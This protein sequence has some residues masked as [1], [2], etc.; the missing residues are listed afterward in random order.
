[1]HRQGHWELLPAKYSATRRLLILIKGNSVGL[2]VEQSSR[3]QSAILTLRGTEAQIEKHMHN[4]DGKINVPRINK[5][6]S[7]HADQVQELLISIKD[8]IGR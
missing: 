2:T 8:K 1:M 7:D 5:I 6:I 4:R 3:I